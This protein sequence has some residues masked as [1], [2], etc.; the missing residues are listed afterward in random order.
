MDSKK[1]ILFLKDNRCEYVTKWKNSYAEETEFIGVPITGR[2]SYLMLKPSKYMN[3]KRAEITFR[4]SYVCGGDD[5]GDFYNIGDMVTK[6]CDN[7]I[8][9]FNVM[10]T[11]N[12]IDVYKL[13]M[14]GNCNY[15]YED[16]SSIQLDYFEIKLYDKNNLLTYSKFVSEED[17]FSGF[18]TYESTFILPL[19]D[20]YH[21]YFGGLGKDFITI[22]NGKWKIVEKMSS[23]DPNKVYG[24]P[25]PYTYSFIFLN[26][27]EVESLKLIDY[28]DYAIFSFECDNMTYRTIRNLAFDNYINMEHLYTEIEENVDCIY[29][30]DQSSI[31]DSSI[32]HS[33][34]WLL[35]ILTYVD[36]LFVY[37]LLEQH[38]NY[39]SIDESFRI[40]IAIETEFNNWDNESKIFSKR[41]DLDTETVV[42][43]IDSLFRAIL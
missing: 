35:C 26:Q 2:N 23:S 34:Q 27:E 1:L 4:I 21:P 13:L 32:V 10:H 8:D 18:I 7:F 17:L 9:F 12:R 14:K 33:Y 31:S 40:M 28:I 24:I 36:I 3:F 38:M 20:V 5:V 29:D 30:I 19:K 15:I 37:R 6:E 43:L 11:I 16:A 25:L 39:S 41:F 42:D 22:K